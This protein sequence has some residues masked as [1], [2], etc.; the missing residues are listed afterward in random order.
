MSRREDS[1]SCRQTSTSIAGE[2]VDVGVD[3]DV[4]VAGDVAGAKIS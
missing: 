4:G 3:V 2:E 1:R